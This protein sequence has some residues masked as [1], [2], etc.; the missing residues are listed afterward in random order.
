MSSRHKL[1]SLGRGN[2][3]EKMLPPAGLW[4]SLWYIFLI[5]GWYWRTYL[6][7]NSVSTGKVVLSCMRKQHEQA[8]RE[9]AYKQHS[10]IVSASG[11]AARFLPLVSILMTL[12]DGLQML[13]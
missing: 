2:S 6:T 5:S 13:R 8:M 7:V 9:K 10:S 3:I 1:E 12:N 11:S 4:A